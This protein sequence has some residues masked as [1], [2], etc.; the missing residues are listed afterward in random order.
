M[1]EDFTKLDDV[2]PFI[3]H[4]IRY[5]NISDMKK[6]M[7]QFGYEKAY[8]KNFKKQLNPN[9]NHENQRKHMVK[10]RNSLLIMNHFKN[11]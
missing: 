5:C 11:I 2:M 7:K 3:E 8:E 9:F 1:N 6:Y 4:F 10:F